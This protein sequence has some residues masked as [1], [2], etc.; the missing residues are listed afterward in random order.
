MMQATTNSFYYPLPQLTLTI[1]ASLALL[2]G[3]CQSKD[4]GDVAA[5]FDVGREALM[6]GDFEIADA[7]LTRF[8]EAHAEHHLGSRATF[9]L[10]KC[11]LGQ[12]DL[13]AATLW[14]QRTTERFPR[15]EEAHKALYKLAL[16]DILQGNHESAMERLQSLVDRPAGPY[17]PEATAYLAFLKQDAAPVAP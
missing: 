2:L 10:A 5:Q 14:F 7:Q 13:Q 12:G 4:R 16:I 11:K 8:I 1:T 17:V 15:T 3:G 9:L 6:Q